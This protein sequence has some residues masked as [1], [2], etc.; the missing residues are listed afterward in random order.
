MNSISPVGLDV[1]KYQELVH[2]TRMSEEDKLKEATRQFEGVMLR[3]FLKESLKPLIKSDMVQ[4]SAANDI[5]R[6]HLVDIMADSM[7]RGP[8]LG[9]TTS[10]QAAVTR[11][12]N[13]N[14]NNTHETP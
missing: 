5:Y 1:A 3:Q 8:G 7:T 6:S 14:D 13:S 11:N 12:A 2:S 4:S 9:I 10:L